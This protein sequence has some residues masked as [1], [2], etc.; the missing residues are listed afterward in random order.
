[1]KENDLRKASVAGLFYPSVKKELMGQISGFLHEIPNKPLLKNL[2][3]VIV[4]HAGY[5][6]SGRVAAEVYCLPG[7][8]KFESC[9]I[10]GPNH[11]GRGGVGASV[12]AKG[13]FETP[14]GHM[15][16]DE[17]LADTI[18]KRD[19]RAVF[20]REAHEGEHSIEVQIPFL[21]MVNPSLKIVPIVMSDYRYETCQRLSLAIQDAIAAFP[22]KKILIM[23]STDFSHYH[24]HQFAVQMDALAIDIIEKSDPEGLFEKAESGDVELCG[25]GPALVLM[26]V[27][28]RQGSIEVQA[29][30][31]KNSGDVTGDRT[32][33]VGYAAIVFLKK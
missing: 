3:G 1:M 29:L 27:L 25:L 20:N 28:K 8:Q 12:Y 14:L 10:L 16:I 9:I 4:P 31:Y 6:Y 22:V 5:I 30:Q 23:A 19:D 13:S 26:M 18:L 11:Q 24:T 21:Q 15:N 2:I 33:V 17:E 7:L 32:S